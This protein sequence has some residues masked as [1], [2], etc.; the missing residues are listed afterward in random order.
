MGQQVYIIDDDESFG[1]SLKRLLRSKGLQ[2]DCFSS[3]QSFL[4]SVPS[5]QIGFAIIDLHMPECDGLSLID[6]MRELRYEMPF[7]VITGQT[8]PDSRDVS[9]QRGA[10]GFLQKPFNEQSLLDLIEPQN[11][12]AGVMK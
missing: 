10:I 11:T 12:D 8:E 1:R 4:D 5:G 2:A 3:A 6:K 7:I 9:L